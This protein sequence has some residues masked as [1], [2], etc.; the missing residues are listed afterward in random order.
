MYRKSD[1]A[2][3]AIRRRDK[4]NLE[5]AAKLPPILNDSITL[6]LNSINS[7]LSY[8]MKRALLHTQ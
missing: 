1:Q 4:L 8:V 5:L 6:L 7:K 3:L 2:M